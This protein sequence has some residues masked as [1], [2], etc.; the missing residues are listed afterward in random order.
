[1]QS[2]SNAALPHI[3][4]P[5]T[6]KKRRRRNKR[7]LHVPVVPLKKVMTSTRWFSLAMLVICTWSIVLI[8]RDRTFY[9]EEIPVQGASSIP[10]ANIIASSGLAGTHIIAADPK[11]AADNISQL[12]GVISATVTIEWPNQASIYVTED[13]PTLIWKQAGQQYWVNQDG[14]LMPIGLNTT[15]L[16]VVESDIAE[17]LGEAGFVPVEVLKGALLLQELR[18][19]IKRLGYE[20]G[21]G[22]SFDDGR[23]WRVYFGSGLD[24][25]QK[26][27]VYEAIVEDLLERSIQPTLISVRN[28]TKP[29]Y[30]LNSGA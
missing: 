25:E 2:T 27:V 11:E 15:N 12:P 7:H 3:V 5:S 8:G 26:L 19:N 28:P 1:M 23:G 9:L 18:P 16:L 20:P 29:F 10:A 6:A 17:L 30:R 21:S 22:L 14:R 4:V 24:M 13:L